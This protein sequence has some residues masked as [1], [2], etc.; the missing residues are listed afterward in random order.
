MWLDKDELPRDRIE[1]L[2]RSH[3][4]PPYFLRL[5]NYYDY[6][7]SVS[8]EG[9]QKVALSLLQSSYPIEDVA[10]SIRL[11]ARLCVFFLD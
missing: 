7:G 6:A 10:S 5:R 4:L 3:E 1:S 9:R 8:T 2:V 11:A